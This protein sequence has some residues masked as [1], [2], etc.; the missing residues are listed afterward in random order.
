[1]G[2]GRSDI[3]LSN[4]I[5]LSN[6]GPSSAY[7]DGCCG[8][9][10]VSAAHLTVADHPSIPAFFI[11][12]GSTEEMPIE[13]S[14]CLIDKAGTAF[15]ASQPADGPLTIVHRNTLAFDVDALQETIEGSP[16][17]DASGTV[18][19]DPLLSDDGHIREGSAAIDSGID[20]GILVD[21]DGD[22]RPQ[23]AGW[24]IGADELA[25]AGSSWATWIPVVSHASGANSAQWRSDLALFNPTNDD[26]SVDIILHTEE[27][28]SNLRKQIPGHHQLVFSDIAGMFSYTGS[29]PLAIETEYPLI[30][31]S[32]SYA[33]VD[34][35]AECSPG[36]TLGQN[37]DATT[38][39]GTLSSG[40]TAWILQLEETAAF[41]SNIGIL[42]SGSATARVKVH[43]FDGGR[44][45]ATSFVLDIPGGTW[46]QENRVFSNRAGLE[47]VSSGFVLLEVI[48]GSG[49]SAYGSVVDNITND[50][51]TM[52]MLRGA[53]NIVTW[54]PV[55]S[56]APGENGARWRSDL[57]L[58]NP[59]PDDCSAEIRL[60]TSAGDFSINRTFASASQL[61]I[62]DLIGEYGLDGAGAVE[63]RSDV[64]L[65]ASSRSYSLVGAGDPCYAGGTLGQNLDALTTAS[66]L[67][68]GDSAWVPQLIENS[69]FR[70]NIGLI[71]TGDENA[72]VEL[73]LFD[74]SGNELKTITLEIL[75]GRW[76][77]KN[78]PFEGSAIDSGNVRIDVLAGNG[79]SAYGSV[80]D[81]ITNDPTTV[82]MIR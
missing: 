20:S 17:F 30:V 29:A 16:V 80:V 72:R 23:G 81:N 41:R 7:L 73:H 36:G 71:N 53:R 52:P 38:T 58:F 82:L 43:L 51:A 3:E 54:I 46:V 42:N 65:L 78:R 31:A 10:S 5:I 9:M 27:G 56:H 22:I 37:L 39:T 70:S 50:P 6:T 2:S 76:T 61:I 28:S 49:V 48:A 47:D 8:S 13:F 44:D 74:E 62:P 79:V 34:G 66:G 45:E 14:N 55:A 35:D 11:E 77:Q 68:T 32:R 64:P 67:S 21:F 57:A 40:G 75:P 26:N 4:L 60:H 33:L 12:N 59:G 25:S 1:M 63:I 24:D 19:G 69:G 15:K 18:T